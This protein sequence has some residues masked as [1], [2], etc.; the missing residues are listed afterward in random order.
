LHPE[1]STTATTLTEEEEQK[2]IPVTYAK[3][4]YHIWDMSQQ[5]P[6][7]SKSTSTNPSDISAN[8]Q[9]N[10]DSKHFYLSLAVTDES[11]VKGDEILLTLD[12]SNASSSQVTDEKPK[13]KTKNT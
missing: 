9:A 13:D 4:P 5:R 7:L 3:S 11:I 8:W 10:W 1:K 12:A 6:I 2:N